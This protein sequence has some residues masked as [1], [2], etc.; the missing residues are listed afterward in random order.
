MLFSL[1][2]GAQ[3]GGQFFENNVI[4]VEYVGYFNGQHT[5]K[6]HNKQNCQARIRTKA[7]QD[8]AIDIQVPPNSHVLVYVTRPTSASILFRA[9][10][11]TFCIS[12]PDM[13]WLEIN[14][15][16]TPLSLNE[17]I[18]ES[19]NELNRG[20][21]VTYK[22][23]Y[24]RVATDNRSNYLQTIIVFDA[25]GFKKYYKSFI[26][27]KSSVLYLHDQIRLGLNFISIRLD[28]NGMVYQ[29]LIRSFY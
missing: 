26:M 7:D 1:I 27:S 28:R 12:N 10:A 13:G 4:R 21:S 19:R 6:V 17:D 22:V 18:S 11:E 24:L 16:L 23:G 15:A 5:F 9:K 20:I 8:P 3:N 29:Y 2:A 25:T 14:T